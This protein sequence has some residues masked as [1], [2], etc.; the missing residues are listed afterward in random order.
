MLIKYVN[1]VNDYHTYVHSH[2]VL[3]SVG[4][5]AQTLMYAL[6][7]N[8]GTHTLARGHTHTRTHTGI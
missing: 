6:N 1:Y 5:C 7:A 2:C 8:T 3:K 4:A